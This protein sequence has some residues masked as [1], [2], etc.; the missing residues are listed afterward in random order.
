MTDKIQREPGGSDAPLRRWVDRGDG[1]YAPEVATVGAAGGG[2]TDAELRAA[3]VEV[4][5]PPGGG[6]L[7]DTELRATPVPVSGTVA[8]TEPVSVDDNGASLTVD[9]AVS[10]SNFPATQPVSAAALPLPAGAS[11]EATLAGIKTGTDKIPAAPAATAD[12]QAVRDRLPAALDADGG[13]KVHLQ[14]ADESGLTDVQLRA[15][16]VPV[17]GPVTDAQLRASAVPVS[18]SEPISVD[19]NG[20]SLT[21]DVGT[22]L[23]TG[24]NNIGNVD[25]LTL[26]ALVAGSANIGDVDVLTINGQAP[27]FGSGVRGATVQRVTNATDDTYDVLDRAAR[28]VGRARIW[29]GTDEATVL[30]V[31]TQPA[32]TEKALSTINL[33]FRMPTYGCTTIAIAPAITIGVKELLAIW[34]AAAGAKDKYIV[35]IVATGIVTTAGTAGRSAL[36]VSTIT[37]APT[38]GTEEAK[39]DLTGA[40]ASDLTNTMRVKTGG[41]TIGSTFVRRHVWS[42]TQAVNSRVEVPLF[43]AQDPRNAIILRAGVAAGFSIDIEREVAHTALVDQWTVGIRWLEL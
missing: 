9:G 21:V 7:T 16:A 11:T 25:V 12:V 1:T 30:P 39:V 37:T 29:D 24:D 19:D 14:N 34:A 36:R 10:V 22:A 41:G 4:T 13:V 31:R 27:A 8:V 43:M 5:L 17:S 35:E 32:T 38:G 23:P 6:G 26:P 40:G 33:P 18:L 3:P 20:G 42:T 15:S 28:E 2:L